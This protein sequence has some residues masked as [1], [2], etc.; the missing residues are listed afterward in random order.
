MKK[1][2]MML[3]CMLVLPQL[4]SVPLV[5]AES[6]SMKYMTEKHVEGVPVQA[7]I[8]AAQNENSSIVEAKITKDE[9]LDIAKQFTTVPSEYSQQ[10]VN[11]QSN[12][13]PGNRN[14]WNISWYKEG[15][16][17]YGNISITVDAKTGTVVAMNRWD[18]SLNEQQLYPPKYNRESALLIAEQFLQQKAPHKVNAVK[19]DDTYQAI[20]KPPLQGNAYYYFSFLRV[21][22]NIPFTEQLISVTVNGNGE[23]TGYEYRW[24]EDVK[25]PPT[26]GMMSQAEAENYIKENYPIEL[27][28]QTFYQSN[29]MPNKPNTIKLTYNSRAEYPYIDAKSKQWLDY[30]GKA[31]NFDNLST[32]LEPLSSTKQTQPVKKELTQDEAI[33]I[34]KDKFPIL[35]NMRLENIYFNDRNQYRSFPSWD[36]TWVKGN[37]EVWIYV[38]INGDTGEIINFSKDDPSIYRPVSDSETLKQ[39]VD[40]E[41]AKEKAFE[42]L[43]KFAENRLY[44]LTFDP[45]ANQKP[46]KPE[47]MREFNF[48]FHRIINGIVVQDHFYNISISS[49]TGEIIRLYQNWD[50]AL[51]IPAANNAISLEK[52]KEIYFNNYMIKPRYVYL[53]NIDYSS[54]FPKGKPEVKLVYQL[55]MK[56]QEYGGVYLDAEK[57]QWI[58]METGE[59]IREKREALDIQGHPAEKA[60]KLLID[61]QAIDLDDSGYVKPNEEMTRGEMIKTLMLVTNPDPYYYK[62]VFLSADRVATFKDVENSSPYFA[63]VESA[64]QQGLIDKTSGEF[65]PN[66]PITREELAELI[67][68]AMKLDKLAQAPALFNINFTD[69]DQIQKKV[70]AAIVHHLKIMPAINGKFEPSQKVTR[71]EGAQVFYQFLQERGKYNR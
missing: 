19:L 22:N 15:P 42:F 55:M 53:E 11:Y 70:E 5:D 6:T 14:V 62:M 48:N 56:P 71:G 38:S 33:Q 65:K 28:Y 7:K 58:S 49:E 69:A 43:K 68:K 64:V 47:K 30:S 20:E 63:Y 1:K 27:K 67:V 21:E 36:L 13:Y 54:P 44:E 37:H 34:A 60:L 16:T 17:G 23:V 29:F 4:L 32:K 12:W 3:S 66:E 50:D 8:I 59:V 18:D 61:Y 9:A 45:A 35:S 10:S 25:V 51:E 2:A 24:N 57:G 52:A 41:K 39:V 31:V 26:E 46:E 40:Y